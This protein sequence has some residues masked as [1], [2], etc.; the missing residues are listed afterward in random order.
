ML[1]KKEIKYV[2]SKIPELKNVLK[3]HRHVSTLGILSTKTC[4]KTPILKCFH[5]SRA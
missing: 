3:I 4:Y 5:Y 1:L 2:V